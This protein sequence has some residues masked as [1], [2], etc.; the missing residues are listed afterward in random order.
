MLE[1]FKSE[2]E[3]IGVNFAQMINKDIETASQKT[4]RQY[5]DSMKM[6]LEEIRLLNHVADTLERIDRMSAFPFLY[7]GAATPCN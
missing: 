3:S 5:D 7:S 2:V 4:D 1:N 6:I